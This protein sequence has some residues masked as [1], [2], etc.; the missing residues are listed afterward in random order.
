MWAREE[1]ILELKWSC[2]Q[3]ET[4]SSKMGKCQFSFSFFLGNLVYFQEVF[5]NLEEGV[6]NSDLGFGKKF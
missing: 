3:M 2:P 5:S 4:S 6:D 1:I